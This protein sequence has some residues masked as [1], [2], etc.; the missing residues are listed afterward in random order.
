MGRVEDLYSSVPNCVPPAERAGDVQR[1]AG[2]DVRRGTGLRKDEAGRWRA[3]GA[4]EWTGMLW[5]EDG[6]AGKGRSKE[7]GL[8]QGSGWGCDTPITP[9]KGHCFDPRKVP[10]MRVVDGTEG[11]EFQPLACENRLFIR[12]W[13]S[14]RHFPFLPI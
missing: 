3:V 11:L 4:E 5:Q 9:I 14:L 10:L 7:S 8:S 12:N 13:T 1:M 6:M 2:R